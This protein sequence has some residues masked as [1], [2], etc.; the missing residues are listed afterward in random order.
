MHVCMLC[1]C[2]VRVLLY[3]DFFSHSPFIF[4][5][6]LNLL[7]PT[8][9]IARAHKAG[10]RVQSWTFRSE[11]IYLNEQYKTA[12]DEFMHF[13]AMGIDGGMC[14]SHVLLRGVCRVW[15]CMTVCLCMI[16]I[17]PKLLRPLAPFE[18]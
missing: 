18:R 11:R 15:W 3:T 13:F 5:F 7:Q 10:L 4:S 9:L 6:F 14:I 8:D 2:C 1:C 16:V 12:E 17:S